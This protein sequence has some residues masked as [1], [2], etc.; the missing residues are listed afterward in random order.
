[1]G[2]FGKKKKVVSG[3]DIPPAPPPVKISEEVSAP[4]E[5]IELPEFPSLP[6]FPPPPGKGL[7]T[8]EEGLKRGGKAPPVKEAIEKEI[9]P[10]MEEIPPPPTEE[11][12][13]P[14]PPMKAPLPVKAK[15]DIPEAPPAPGIPPP[16][17]KAPEEELPE[18]PPRPEE[19]APEMP[20]FEAVE[21][22]IGEEEKVGMRVTEGPIFIRADNYRY[23]LD[24]LSVARNI[25]K[26]SG[27]LF[28]G[29]ENISSSSEQAYENWRLC[30]EDVERKLLYVDKSLFGGG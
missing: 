26:E 24:E 4:P 20:S 29:I 10:P 5:A 18:A 6:E 7:P 9:P 14:P 11:M 16:P 19:A 27:E 3:L 1:M 23:V 13:M 25:V 12:E 28:A 15:G 22:E 8:F 17:M 21:E 2:L 30:L